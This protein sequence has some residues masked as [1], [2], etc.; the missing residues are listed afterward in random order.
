[1]ITVIGLE[2][3]FHMVRFG[4]GQIPDLQSPAQYAPEPE[5]Y[6]Q[7]VEDIGEGLP[8]RWSELMPV[9]LSWPFLAAG[10]RCASCAINLSADGMMR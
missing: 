2:T 3:A 5:S 9:N 8:G 10:T 4:A 6:A 1:M 7:L